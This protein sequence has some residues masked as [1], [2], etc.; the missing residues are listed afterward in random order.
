M[1]TKWREYARTKNA[2]E[3]LKN[4]LIILFSSTYFGV[5]IFDFKDENSNHLL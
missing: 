5:T 1:Y 2:G 4:V 3:T